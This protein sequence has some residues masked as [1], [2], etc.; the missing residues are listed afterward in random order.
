MAG[1]EHGNKETKTILASQTSGGGKRRKSDGKRVHE[2][3]QGLQHR[4]EGTQA[5]FEAG[6]INQY[7]RARVYLKMGAQDVRKYSVV[8]ARAALEAKR[9]LL[10][11]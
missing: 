9:G 4:R 3:M 8:E 5:A 1:F 2:F 6:R 10:V 7:S 11:G